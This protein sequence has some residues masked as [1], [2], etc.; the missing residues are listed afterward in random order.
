MRTRKRF[1]Y[2]EWVWWLSAALMVTGGERAG[3]GEC[4]GGLPPLTGVWGCPPDSPRHPS[5]GRVGGSNHIHVT[6]TTPTPP[7]RTVPRVDKASPLPREV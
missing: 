7:T 2:V 1:L 5:G 3:K 4:R 6:A